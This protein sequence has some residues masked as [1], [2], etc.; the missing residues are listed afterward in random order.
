MLF[1]GD[2][3][4]SRDSA[5]D[6]RML[7]EVLQIRLREVLR[8]DMGGVYGVGASGD[9]SRR[10][11][12]RFQFTVSFGCDPQNVDKLEKA[13]R[14]VMARP[15]VRALPLRDRSQADPGRACAR[16]PGRL[17]A[18]AGGGPALPHRQE[19]DRRGA[20]AREVVAAGSCRR[21]ACVAPELASAAAA[22]APELL[23]PGLAPALLII[24][25]DDPCRAPAILASLVAFLASPPRRPRGAVARAG[26]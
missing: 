2:Q 5:D 7:G 8:E 19:H 12:Q 20:G 18:G 1:H 10:P 17:G 6:L 3:K 25:S 16:R 23:R 26:R 22:I 21:I 11:R 4:W 13:V 9:I 24:D 14:D 15:P